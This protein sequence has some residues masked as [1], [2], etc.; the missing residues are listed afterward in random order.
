MDRI[1]PWQR[2][3][4]DVGEHLVVL[5]RIAAADV[6]LHP[7]RVGADHQQ[8][9]ARARIAVAGAGRQ[10]EHVVSVIGDGFVPTIEA[11]L[12]TLTDPGG[13]GL[14]YRAGE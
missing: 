5:G 7:V 9:P 12:L 11:N 2:N 6:P 8:L 14:V 1:G 3:G 10:D 4:A 13:V